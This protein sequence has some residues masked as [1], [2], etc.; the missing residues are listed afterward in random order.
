MKIGK[1]VIFG[2]NGMLGTALVKIFKYHDVYAFSKAQA[3]ITNKRDVFGK[4]D[5]IKPF[6]VINLA[7]YTN[8]DGC[9]KNK[10]H[11]FNVNGEAVK[12][13]AEACKKNNATLLHISTDYV[14]DGKKN[15][16]TENDKTN[17]INIYGKSKE[18]GEKYLAETLD[19]YYLIRTSWL[20]GKYG[21]NFVN[22]ILRLAK[23][24][25]E[26]RIVNDQ[27]GRP[28][29][30]KDLSKKIKEIVEA[31]KP[32]GIYHITNSGTCTWF[33]FAEKVIKFA[34]LNS[35]VKPITSEELNRAAK[36]P[37]YSVLLNTKLLPL[38][39]WHSALKECIRV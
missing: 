24:K 9:E 4:I 25:K 7:A 16:Y 15:G 27:F 6:I 12:V 39:H 1:I 17:P 26:L 32:F 13:I 5:K 31:K 22:T 14:F 10:R 36:R 28:T 3:N 20:F 8:V 18:L 11:A 38:R 33:Q 2:A 19:R 21:K 37:K 29:Y 34:E 23:D 35:E 30:T